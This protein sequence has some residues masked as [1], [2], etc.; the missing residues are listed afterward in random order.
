MAAA[1]L[2][3]TAAPAKAASKRPWSAYSVTV[4]GVTHKLGV[5]A[6]APPKVRAKVRRSVARDPASRV[7]LRQSAATRGVGKSGRVVDYTCFADCSYTVTAFDFFGGCGD[8]VLHIWSGFNGGTQK[9][10]TWSHW[11]ALGGFDIGN[12]PGLY[13]SQ[14]SQTGWPVGT[15]NNINPYFY[16]WYAGHPRSGYHVGGEAYWVTC[17]PGC[18]FWTSKIDHYMHSDGTEY[19]H[20]WGAR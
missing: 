13:T 8:V 3:A 2:L 9:F 5:T 17:T 12:T 20:M 1:L 15:N 4:N 6:N 14:D 10:H 18:R 16:S 11:C 7:I 19:F